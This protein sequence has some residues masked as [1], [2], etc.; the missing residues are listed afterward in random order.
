MCLSIAI[1][2]PD[3]VLAKGEHLGYEWAV[4]HNRSGYRCGYVRVP[5]GHPWHGKD[6][7][8]IPV[9]VHGSLTFSEAD[10]PCSNPGPDNAWWVG[11]DCAH[12]GDAPDP[13]L[14][15][16]CASIMITGIPPFPGENLVVRTQEYVEYECHKLCEQADAAVLSLSRQS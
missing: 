5:D 15:T 14:L 6:Y 8:D 16:K 2:R 12:Y 13:H 1:H 4:I 7:D 3:D 11:F 9:D 10:V